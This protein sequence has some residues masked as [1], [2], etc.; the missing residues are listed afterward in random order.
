MAI[1]Y[2][3]FCVGMAWYVVFC[4]RVPGVY[5]SWAVAHA[6]VD[7]FPGNCYKKYPTEGEA[8]LAFYGPGEPVNPQQLEADNP[9]LLQPV[10]APFIEE[11][12]AHH[13]HLCRILV[14]V[15]I[16]V[17]VVLLVAYLIS[18]LM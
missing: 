6:Q 1:A 8:R 18:K 17:V 15:V 4:G 11:F 2:D 16:T 10:D 9:P 13:F 7:G 12:E 5:S 14:N 3:D